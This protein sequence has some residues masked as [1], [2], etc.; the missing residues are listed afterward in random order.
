MS[1]LPPDAERD[2]CFIESCD[3]CEADQ[4]EQR[5]KAL[6]NPNLSN[7]DETALTCAASNSHDGIVRLLLEAGAD[8]GWKDSDWENTA[9]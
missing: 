5:L 6:Q 9:L 4:V 3:D 2:E 1:H 8:T 7:G